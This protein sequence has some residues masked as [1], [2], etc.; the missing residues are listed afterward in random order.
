MTKKSTKGLVNDYLGIEGKVKQSTRKRKLTKQKLYLEICTRA[1]SMETPELKSFL[2][3]LQ[4][5]SGNPLHLVQSFRT[6]Q[7]F[8]RCAN[9]LKDSLFYAKL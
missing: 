7:R 5:T 8:R 3:N 1:S 4:E 6:N 2:C 9:I